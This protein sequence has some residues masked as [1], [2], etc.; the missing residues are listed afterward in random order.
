MPPTFYDT[1]KMVNGMEYSKLLTAAVINARFCHHL[2]TDPAKALANGFNGE[3]FELD[4]ELRDHIL[5]IKANSLPEFARQLLGKRDEITPLHPT[6]GW[7][8]QPAFSPARVS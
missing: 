4:K 3:S 5:A 7:A 8:V 6:K 2:L 1:N